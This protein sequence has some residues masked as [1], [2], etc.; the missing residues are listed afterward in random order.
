MQTRILGIVFTT[1]ATV[2]GAAA[3][4]QAQSF[5]YYGERGPAHWGSLGE[6]YATCEA[7]T[8]QSPVDFGRIA[9]LTT[10]HLGVTLH[11]GR[12]AGTI[13]NNGHTVEVETEGENTLVLDGVDYRLVQFHFHT[14]SEH[15]FDGQGADME[16]HLVHRGDTGG[17]AVLGVLLV[18]GD[19][20]RALAPV[21]EHLPTEIGVREPFETP[22]NPR[23]FLPP[24]LANYRY[25]GSLTTP[26][27]TE[28]VRWVVLADPVTV[29]DEEM[30]KFAAGISFNARPIQRRTR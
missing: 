22:F 8:S 9:R 11:Y 20:S 3:A 17:L 14:P 29:S 26:P 2:V 25:A 30:A 13:F 10:R 27:C 16:L 21:F 5:A 28:G 12:T 7:G 23:D 1:A 15:R 4:A 24:S 18:R 6:A 19:S